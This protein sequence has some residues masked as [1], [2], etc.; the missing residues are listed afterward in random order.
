MH[1][2]SEKKK[3]VVVLPA[4]DAMLFIMTIEIKLA[5]A[6]FDMQLINLHVLNFQCTMHN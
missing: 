2:R 6:L 5:E 1:D 3:L 4:L